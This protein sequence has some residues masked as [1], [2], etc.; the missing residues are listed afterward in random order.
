MGLPIGK[1]A[2][3]VRWYNGLAALPAWQKAVATKQEAM[4]AWQ[5]QRGSFRGT[6]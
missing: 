3:I 2:E 5:S 1:F 6:P 4:A